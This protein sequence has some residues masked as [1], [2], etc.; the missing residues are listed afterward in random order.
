MVWDLWMTKE[1]VK[2]VKKKKEAYVWFQ[3]K[4]DRAFEERIQVGDQ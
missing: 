1:V 4:S 2:L 3:M